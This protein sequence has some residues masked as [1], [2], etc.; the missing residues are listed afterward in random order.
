MTARK[1]AVVLLCISCLFAVHPGC[2]DDDA[3]STD[4]DTDTDTGWDSCNEDLAWPGDYFIEE[5]A[6]LELISGFNAVEGDLRIDFPGEASTPESLD[7]LQC[8]QTVGEELRID[9]EHL[10]SLEGLNNLTTVGDGLRIYGCDGLV[11]LSGL[12]SLSSVRG[13]SVSSNDSLTSLDGLDSLGD[14]VTNIGITNNATLTSIAA[15]QGLTGAG[16]QLFVTDNDALVDLN[17]L[18]NIISVGWRFR[19]RWNPQLEDISALGSLEIVGEQSVEC[20]ESQS[21]TDVDGDSDSD[22]DWYQGVFDITHNA[23]LANC[24]AVEIFERLTD[25]G[26]AGCAWIHENLPDECL[27]PCPGYTGEDLCCVPNDPCGWELNDVCDCDA[28]CAWDEVDCEL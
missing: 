20:L 23:S 14:P 10:P 21:D 22:C 8:L 25:N 7:G 18:E 16:C 9:A 2:G 12:E 13:V 5:I 19:I 27:D 3:A 28:T 24:D 15:L 17:G 1:T 11:D 6:D 26:Y 4:A